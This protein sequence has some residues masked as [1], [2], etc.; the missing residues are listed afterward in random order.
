[1]LNYY[2]T[3]IVKPSPLHLAEAGRIRCEYGLAYFD[4]LHCAVAVIEGKVLISYDREAYERVSNLTYSHPAEV[5][6]KVT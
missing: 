3:A 6:N 5:L 2:R 4:I 1:M